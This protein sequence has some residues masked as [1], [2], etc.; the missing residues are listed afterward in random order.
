MQLVT[1]AFLCFFEKIYKIPPT[2]GM[3]MGKYEQFVL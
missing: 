3:F 2:Y 1:A